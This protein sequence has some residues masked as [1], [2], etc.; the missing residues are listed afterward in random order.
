MTNE[1]VLIF[2]SGHLARRVTKLA[3]KAGSEVVTLPAADAAVVENNGL[4]FEGLIERLRLIKPETLSKAFLI[5]DEDEHNMQIMLALMSIHTTLPITISLFNENIT[6]HIKAAHPHIVVVNPARMA[7]PLFVDALTKP[8]TRNLHYAPKTLEAKEKF[9]SDNL[10]EWLA[11]SFFAICALVTTYFKIAEGLSWLDATYFVV[12]TIATV[13]YGDINLLNSIW[14]S[15]LVAIALILCSTFFIWII[16]SL[17]IDRIIKKREQLSLGH[18]KYQYKD[19]VILCGLGRLGYFIVEELLER[20]EKVLVVEINEDSPAI[21]IFRRRGVP[22]YVGNAR[23][24]S[25]LEDVNVSKA[26]ALISVISNDY[27]NLEIGLNAR[28]QQPNL[29][30]ILRIFD[31]QVATNIKNVL[32]IQLALSM[33]ALVDDLVF[34]MN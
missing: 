25:T 19:H 1:R 11:L 2:G 34:E 10:I 30:V 14:Q 18:K 20:G 15:K 28:S 13:G 4:P 22:T 31:D 32:D 21:E 3:E 27:L 12:V 29:R 8:I 33:S 5:D 24:L 7:A 23:L 6:P 16:F 17:T 9:K 26:K